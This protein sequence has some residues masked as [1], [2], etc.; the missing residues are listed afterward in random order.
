MQDLTPLQIKALTNAS[1]VAG[2]VAVGIAATRVLSLNPARRLAALVNDSAQDIYIG[3]GNSV[4]INTGIRLNALGGS[5]E[6]GLYTA[7]PWL[8][9][10]W[11]ISSIANSNLAFIEV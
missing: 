7:F 3:F 2:N 10:I 6:F 11:A 5:F 8:G 4:A 1:T 9:E